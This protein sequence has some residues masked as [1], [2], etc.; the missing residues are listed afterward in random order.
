MVDAAGSVVFWREE[1]RESG[2]DGVCVDSANDVCA[3]LPV[4]AD[5]DAGA[6]RYSAIVPRG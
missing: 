5:E 4:V 1:R 6:G 2:G 3:E